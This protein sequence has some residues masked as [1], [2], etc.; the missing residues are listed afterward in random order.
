MFRATLLLSIFA[1]ILSCTVAMAESESSDRPEAVGPCPQ[2]PLEASR[3]AARD[4]Q[5]FKKM[6]Y[7]GTWTGFLHQFRSRYA[8]C[9]EY[10][11]QA[12]VESAR[13]AMDAAPPRPGPFQ[14][15]LRK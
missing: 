9:P 1:L 7:S 13:Q 15:S 3:V 6:Y 2:T 5:K 11:K 8:A 14:K 4:I 12:Y 10:I